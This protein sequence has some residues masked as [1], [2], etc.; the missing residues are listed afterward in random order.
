MNAENLCRKCSQPLTPQTTV[1]LWDG[2]NYCRQCVEE[3]CPNLVDYALAHDVLEESMMYNRSAALRRS[4]RMYAVIAA[5]F[6]A[7]MAL[8][9]L[10]AGDLCMIGGAFAF[11]LLLA[12]VAAAIQVPGFLWMNKWALPKVSVRD[13]NVTVFR[14]NQRR[15]VPWTF[16]LSKC[17]WYV[18]KIRHDSFLR[19]T[20]APN[21]PAI[22]LVHS[23]RWRGW[24]LFRYRHACG[25]SDEMRELWKGFL[26]LA[27]IPEGRKRRRTG[28]A[29]P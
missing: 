3:A 14:P 21:A 22:I 2:G 10:A 26:R 29:R 28:A 16:P 25:F 7:V 4:L 13:G 18:G 15:S 17:S 27:A 8:P 11:A 23:L 19:L 1:R 6:G 24:E 12:T 5:I 20:D 9:W